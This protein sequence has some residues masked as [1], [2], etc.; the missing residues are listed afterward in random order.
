MTDV[1]VHATGATLAEIHGKSDAIADHFFGDTP[2]LRSDS[3]I[4]EIPKN[5]QADE[6]FYTATITYVAVETVGQP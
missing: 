4:V 3:Y 2:W 6:Q 5:V 1:T